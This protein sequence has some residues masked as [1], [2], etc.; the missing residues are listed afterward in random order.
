MN[1]NDTSQIPAAVSAAKT[2]DVVLLYLGLDGSIENEGQDRPIDVG[3]G[4]PGQQ[5][6]LLRQ[7]VDAAKPGA[8]IAVVL[9]AGSLRV[10]GLDVDAGAQLPRDEMEK[11]AVQRVDGCSRRRNLQRKRKLHTTSAVLAAWLAFSR[12]PE[13]KYRESLFSGDEDAKA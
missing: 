3:L 5:E 7:V 10:E 4:L 9:V 13:K 8:R 11:D 12:I 6:N 2:A 1:S